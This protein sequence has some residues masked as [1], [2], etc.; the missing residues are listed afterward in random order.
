MKALR[1][2]AILNYLAVLKIVKKHDKRFVDTVIARTM[3]P[4]MLTMSFLRMTGLQ[5][6]IAGAA[7]VLWPRGVRWSDRY[8]DVAGRVIRSGRIW[9]GAAGPNVCACRRNA[10]SGVT[11]VSYDSK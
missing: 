6:I 8:A 2:F 3:V 11:P 9:S 7:T 4:T 1:D 10:R 5:Q